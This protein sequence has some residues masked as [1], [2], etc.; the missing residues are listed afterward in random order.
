MSPPIKIYAA[1]EFESRIVHSSLSISQS[2][3]LYEEKRNDSDE[4]F[5]MANLRFISSEGDVMEIT[6][7]VKG[8]VVTILLVILIAS[9]NQYDAS[10]EESSMSLKDAIDQ[11]L[12]TASFRSTGS[13]SGYVA[14]VS[15]T[16][17]GGENLTIELEPSGLEGMILRNAD[18][19]EQDEFIKEIPGEKIDDTSYT[20]KTNVTLGSGENTTLIVTGYCFNFALK[21][22]SVGTQFSLNGSSEKGNIKEIQGILTAFQAIVDAGNFTDSEKTSIEQ[23]ALWISQSENSNKYLE[24]YGDRGYTTNQDGIQAIKD[25]LID[26]GYTPEEV[27]N[28]TALSGK[29]KEPE[30]EDETNEIP[31]EYWYYLLGGIILWGLI[32]WAL[33]YRKRQKY[34]RPRI[35]GVGQ[36]DVGQDPASTAYGKSY[37]HVPDCLRGVQTSTAYGKS[38]S[39][40]PDCLRGVQSSTAYGRSYSHVPDCLRSMQTSYDKPSVDTVGEVGGPQD[41]AS[42][43]Y[44]KSYSH[45]PDCLRSAQQKSTAYGRSYSH[46]PDCLRSM[47][48]SYD[49][50]SVDTVGE[51]GGPQDQASVAYGKSYSHVPDCLRSAQQKSTAYGRSYSHV[52]DCLRSMQ[53]SHDPSKMTEA[54]KLKKKNNIV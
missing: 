47:Q 13:A 53:T 52:P 25:V 12:V 54:E 37:S 32:R 5:H 2:V 33:R 4:K 9:N 27:D 10:G 50:P 46:V 38:Y 17:T 29:Q 3:N 34:E 39:H 14:D 1:M 19:N 11:G 28:I 7:F 21:N 20:P 16:N 44:G 22:P 48:T 15:I 31:P 35:D 18:G 26:L 41:Q 23:L 43:A 40:V 36:P 42:V 30:K 51:V 49:K 6:R 45:V 24:D 8:L